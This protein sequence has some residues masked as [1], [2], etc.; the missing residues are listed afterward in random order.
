MTRLVDTHCHLNFPDLFPE[1]DPAIE[2]AAREG[3]D[4]VIVVG[5]D[6]ETSRRAVAL[7]ERHEGVF[8]VVGWHPNHAA[9]F[10]AIGLGEIEAMLDHPKVVALG[11]IGLDDHWDFATKP[12][13]RTALVEQLD[14]ATR[15]GKPIVFHCREAYPELLDV[16][17]ARKD[18][19]L[20]LL[21]CFSG[22][23]DDA[24]RAVALGAWF[25][26]DGPIT[27]KKAD[28]LRAVVRTLP[29]E[30]L[31]VET[32]SPYLTPHPHRGKPN[33]PAMVTLVNAGL[34]ATLSLDVD[35]CARLTTTNAER[36]FGLG[37]RAA[38]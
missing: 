33:R 25:G 23:A 10:D 14:L 13:Q 16:L 21:H 31:V 8:A 1:P 22:D 18:L 38:T 15:L 17:E 9:T 11:E 7:A 27:Y 30:R 35:A 2:E 3:V 26:V 37:T 32:D 5:C 28:E 12:Q 24:R 19:P 20:I 34:A 6:A 29:S 36:F 4:R